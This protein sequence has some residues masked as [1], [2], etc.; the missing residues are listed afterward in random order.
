MLAEA[1]WVGHAAA[2]SLRDGLRAC[3]A[4]AAIPV[5]E[6]A[7]AA[8][9][10]FLA[11]RLEQQLL[12]EGHPVDRVSAAI[13][14]ASRPQCVDQILA[15]LT[16]FADKPEFLHL[17]AALQRARRILPTGATPN[18][19]Q[20]RLTGPEGALLRQQVSNFRNVVAGSPNL[21]NLLAAARE[22]PSVVGQFFDVVL[23][24]GRERTCPRT[25]YRA[26]RSS[27]RARRGDTSIGTLCGSSSGTGGLPQVHSWRG[28]FE[29]AEFLSDP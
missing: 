10:E 5:T 28:A 14:R 27:R 11:R 12:D 1:N 29:R 26:R 8:I 2:L 21:T 24:H 22:L 18:Y 13:I 6:Q 9:E 3:R 23:R 17:I 16:M 7:L 19:S 4:P 20:E 15:E 25:T